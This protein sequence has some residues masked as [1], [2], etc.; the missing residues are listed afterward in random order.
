[1]QRTRLA[2]GVGRIGCVRRSARVLALELR[3]RVVVGFGHRLGHA[4]IAD[5]GR[6]STDGVAWGDY[7]GSVVD[8]GDLLDL[9][10]IQSVANEEGRGETVIVRVPFADASR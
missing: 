10:T 7:S 6:G 5:G 3:V 9:W 2:R 4:S 8:G 1:M